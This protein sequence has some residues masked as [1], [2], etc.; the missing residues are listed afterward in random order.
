MGL[1]LPKSATCIHGF[2][3]G[4]SY[5]SAARGTEVHESSASPSRQAL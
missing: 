1:G 5:G 3:G 2:P 4:S